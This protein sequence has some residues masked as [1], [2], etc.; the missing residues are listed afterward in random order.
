MSLALLIREL[1][2]DRFEPHVYCPPG[3]AAQIFREA[4][5]DVH[6]GPIAAFT[7]IW[8]SVYRGR[9][10][11]LF[12]RELALLPAHAIAFRRTLRENEFDV[13]HLN[14]SPLIPAAL[15]AR[16][17]RTP[18]VWH[19]RSALPA[20]DRGLRSRLVQSSVRRLSAASIA[21]NAD[22][23]ESFGVG[24]T[25]IP[26]G[27][28]LALFGRG[29]R[30]VIRSRLGLD[31]ERLVVAFFGFIYPSKGFRQFIQAGAL[32]REAGVDAEYL[33][34]G[35]AVR[36]EKFFSTLLGRTLEFLDLA[37]NYEREAIELV[38]ASGLTDR[39][40]FIP[41]TNKTADIY[42]ASDLVVAPST[43][44][45]LGR[46]VLEAAAS[47]VPIVASG[48]ET[49]GGVLVPNVTGVLL[50]VSD[51]E[52]FAAAIVSLSRDEERRSTLGSAARAYAES[53]FDAKQTSAAVEAIYER[54]V[55]RRDRVP[56]LFLH[57]RPELGG[58]PAS[59]AVLVRHLSP[60][61]EAH[62]YCPGGPAAALF[63][64]AGA[65]VHTG[66]VS[67]FAHAWDSPY[68]GLRWLLVG[69]ELAALPAHVRSLN[70]LMRKE[71]FPIV[72]LN[73]SPL[74]AAA[75]VA[76]RHGAKVVWHLRSALAGE[77]RDRR[78]RSVA[79][80]I[81]RWGDTAI[82]I[83]SDVAAR[84]P[85]QLPTSIVYNSVSLSD[86]SPDPVDARRGLG[87]PEDRVLVG[88]AGFVRRPKGW[89]E[90]VRAARILKD[91]GVMA[92]FVII[93]GGVRPPTY[94]KT[95]RGRLLAAFGVVSDE[96]SM[97][98]ELVGENG[99]DDRFS[100]LEFRLDPATVYSALDILTFPNQGV[101]L[102]RPVLEAAA[103][104]KPVIASGS[105]DGAGL[106]VP[107]VTGILLDHPTPEAIA[108]AL[109]VL[110][111]DPA[112]RARMGAAAVL[113]ARAHFDPVE[114]TR[115]VEATY[116][117]LLGDTVSTS[118]PVSA[119][120]GAAH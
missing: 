2:R 26:N 5:A 46:S 114:N 41:F 56:I 85:I 64:A 57:H 8:A 84:F 66:P 104:G 93:G 59:L 77:G 94:F 78:S 80:L 83:D 86:A 97:I 70:R 44:P 88:L 117:R 23:A 25:V 40:R 28:D 113:H 73:D 65:V 12:G 101:G 53:H 102:G 107:G 18:V 29:E 51:A 37:R 24:S 98:K 90:L 72:H 55:P 43:G 92:H 76:H 3:A 6:T 13:I 20:G 110:V 95:L 115:V 120:T 67:V 54:I 112:L 118:W 75:M 21:I 33:I 42:R 50:G 119:R 52:G 48:S 103:H 69:R 39:V 34:V 96:E 19:L 74:L 38:V 16:R 32:V 47:G 35:G 9:R 11:L 31:P 81:D 45:E 60:R 4:G 68:R 36:G 27:V 58:A 106:V 109:R 61:F 22:V 7:H 89:P 63:E 49:G 10:W 71:R 91:E 62:V 108:S 116:D 100:F 15:L 82:A 87:L 1:D 79:R 105:A 14:D 111:G 17:S 30:A 99:L